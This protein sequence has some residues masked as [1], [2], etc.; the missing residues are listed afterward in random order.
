[1]SVCS[2]QVKVSRCVALFLSLCVCCLSL[3]R[4]PCSMLQN[5]KTQSW[6]R[7]CC[8]GSCRRTR[9]S[10]LPPA[11]SLATICYDLMWCWRPPG[12]TTSWTFLCRTS[13]RSWGN[14]SARWVGSFQVCFLL[15]GHSKDLRT[16]WHTRNPRWNKTCTIS[17]DYFASPAASASFF[18]LFFFF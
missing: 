1:M 11:C 10:V 15:D 6:Q 4:M 2:A 8:P 18:M 14:T 17:S 13:F 9:R 7:S 5:P 16:H 12:G 3:C